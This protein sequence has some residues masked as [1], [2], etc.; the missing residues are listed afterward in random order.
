[1]LAGGI[2]NIVILLLTLA[3]FYVLF[4]MYNYYPD[5]H[6]KTLI[7][8][9]NTTTYVINLDRNPDRLQQITKSYEASDIREIPLKR[10]PAILGKNVN[11]EVWL[12]PE[13]TEELKRVEKK[14]YRTH[15]YQLTRGAI[16]CF[17]SHYTLAKQLLGDKRNDY[18]IILE[19]DS[20]ID[21]HGF[22]TIQESMVNAPENWDM[23]L[24]G[25]IR[26]I[27]PV[28]TGNFIEPSGFWGL[29]GYIINK[30]GARILV[31][32][33]ESIHIDGQ[34]DAFISRMIQQKKI[35]VYAYKNPIIFQ[36]STQ[37]TIQMGIRLRDD[38]NPYDY[39]GY[40][41]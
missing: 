2:K 30:K 32:E 14:G 7:T 35:H 27:N 12:T 23:V 10:F 17:L 39:K 37:S 34:L 33:V 4:M 25:F 41:V 9:K 11:I 15:H 6:G 3:V 8:S 1:M 21:T 19:D 29:H 36:S 16:G 24:F 20:V 40:I 26:M 38:V 5:N 22:R 13:A 18:Y 28:V 31:D